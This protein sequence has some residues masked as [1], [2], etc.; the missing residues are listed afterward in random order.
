MHDVPVVN[1]EENDGNTIS[2][3]EIAAKSMSNSVL[4]YHVELNKNMNKKHH[5][6]L[7]EFF[8]SAQN[9]FSYA[10]DCERVSEWRGSMDR[11][12]CFCDISE[13]I[14]NDTAWIQWLSGLILDK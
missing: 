5:K 4:Q 11:S 7:E 9:Y 6:F 13:K 1:A 2:R 10:R 3:I 12:D 14:K 8:Q